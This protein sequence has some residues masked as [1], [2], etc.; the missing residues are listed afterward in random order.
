MPL[1]IYDPRILAIDLRPRRSGF[2]IFEGPRRLLDYGTFATPS[3]QLEKTI[4]NRLVDIQKLALPDVVVVKKERWEKLIALPQE[5]SFI[6][7]LNGDSE[8]SPTPIRLLG[9]GALDSTYGNLG[10]ET[11]AEV[12]GALAKIFPELVWQLPPRRKMWESEHPRQ[13]VF[14]AIALGFAY[15]QNETTAI[16]SSN[17]ELKVWEANA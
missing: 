4:G 3:G 12:S 1:R 11:K 15:W 8:T 7:T 6:E 5:T 9:Q 2:A 16:E 10:C 14:D 13:T 17:G